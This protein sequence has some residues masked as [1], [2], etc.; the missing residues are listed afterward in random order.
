MVK[1]WNQKEVMGNN[2][3]NNTA[4]FLAWMFLTFLTFMAPDSALMAQNAD[5]DTVTTPFRKGR[6]LSGLSGSFSS[7]TLKLGSSEDLFSS[8]SYGIE[9]FSGKFFR[10]RW[11]VGFNLLAIRSNGSGLIESESEYLLIGPSLS[12]Y[13]LKEPYGS[14]YVSVLPGYIRIREERSVLLG[15][16]ILTQNAEGPGFGTRIRLGYSYVISGKI[17]LD[18]GVGSS[19]AWLDVSY[20]PEVEAVNRKES[21]FSSGTFFSFGFNVLLDEFFF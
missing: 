21:I 13:F 12:H 1:P 15:G 5:R 18:V 4:T 11:F 7:S 19:L 16:N 17:V 8:N 9:I 6:W 2:R 3:K 14:L 10:D 20:R